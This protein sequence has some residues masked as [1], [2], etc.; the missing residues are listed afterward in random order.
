MGYK[1]IIDSMRNPPE[2][3]LPE[4]IYDDLTAEYDGLVSGSEAAIAERET[5]N[6]SLA[7]E[8]AALKAKNYDLL[9]SVQ[10]GTE[11]VE[12]EQEE[13]DAPAIADLFT[14]ED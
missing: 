13:N 8:N 11:P 9:M 1:E 5:A 4:S 10:T 6:A 14:E 7:T 12:Q 2:E 3:G